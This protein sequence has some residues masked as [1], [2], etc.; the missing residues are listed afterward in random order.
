MKLTV[1]G[2]HM[3]L[4]AADRQAIDRKVKKLERVLNDSAISA[5][6]VVW[7][8]RGVAVCE[9]TVHARSD[10]MLHGVAR[11]AR[12]AQAVGFAVDKVAQQAL[13][14]K[15]R[16][17]TRRRADVGAGQG[18]RRG[19]LSRKSVLPARPAAKTVRPRRAKSVA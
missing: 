5:Q 17:T 3:E 13:K 8:Q 10:Q 12:L 7:Q 9:L 15:D 14:V 18:V 16:W 2:R 1:T 4:S 19:A 6:C 11:H